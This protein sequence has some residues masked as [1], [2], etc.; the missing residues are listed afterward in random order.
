MS[1]RALKH[2]V[3]QAFTSPDGRVQTGK[4]L[5][6]GAID[7][8]SRMQIAQDDESHFMGLLKLGPNHSLVA[9]KPTLTDKQKLEELLTSFGVDKPVVTDKENN[10]GFDIGVLW[11]DRDGECLGW[12]NE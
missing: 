4:Y 9:S 3:E 8:S 2:L 12:R 11:F 6:G 7:T 10:N 1:I 5:K